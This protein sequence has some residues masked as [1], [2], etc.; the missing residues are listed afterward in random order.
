MMEFCALPE[1]PKGDCP[2]TSSCPVHVHVIWVLRGWW[3]YQPVHLWV[4]HI[5][6]ASIVAELKI[7]YKEKWANIFP[8]WCE[9]LCQECHNQLCDKFKKRIGIGLW[10]YF[11]PALYANIETTSFSRKVDCFQLCLAYFSRDKVKL[12]I[13]SIPTPWLYF[14][15]V[16]VLHFPACSPLLTL[17]Q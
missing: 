15:R 4:I 7:C 2:A 5:G 14:P 1:N 16:W 13:S 8:K 11:I 9:R 17:F 12:Y 10:W 6:K 3:L